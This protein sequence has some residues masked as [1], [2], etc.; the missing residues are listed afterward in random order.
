MKPPLLRHTLL[1]LLLLL[2]STLGAS[3][4]YREDLRWS[5]KGSQASPG[6]YF[7]PHSG[8]FRESPPDA[9][10]VRSIEDEIAR[11]D[12]AVED[13][14]DEE[15]PKLGQRGARLSALSNR[16]RR[17]KFS[18]RRQ[19]QVDNAEGDADE[20]GSAHQ[21]R[22]THYNDPGEIILLSASNKYLSDRAER[23]NKQYRRDKRRY[24][25]SGRLRHQLRYEYDESH[26]IANAIGEGERDVYGKG[27]TYN[28]TT[29]DY[30]IG[31][32]QRDG[33]V[34]E[35]PLSYH[36]SHD[37]KYY[38]YGERPIIPTTYRPAS[39]NLFEARRTA[40]QKTT[41]EASTPTTTTTSEPFYPTLSNWTPEKRAKSTQKTTPATTTAIPPTTSTKYPK[42]EHRTTTKAPRRRPKTWRPSTNREVIRERFLE[43]AS[44][45][46]G[47]RNEIADEYPSHENEKFPHFP[48]QKRKTRPKIEFPTVKKKKPKSGAA[49]SAPSSRAKAPRLD[50]TLEVD[51]SAA[52][53][54]YL[55][56]EQ[57][58]MLKAKKLNLLSKASASSLDDGREGLKKTVK[59]GKKVGGF[60]PSSS[61]RTTASVGTGDEWGG[62]LDSTSP[63]SAERS[64]TTENAQSLTY[65]DDSDRISSLFLPAP[66]PAADSSPNLP[67]LTPKEPPP[68]AYGAP[69]LYGQVVPR[70]SKK[71]NHV[72]YD[73]TEEREIKKRPTSPQREAGEGYRQYHPPKVNVLAKDG[74]LSS[75]DVDDDFF[76]HAR[77][78]KRRENKKNKRHK[79]QKAATLSPYYKPALSFL[80]SP[81]PASAPSSRQSSRQGFAAVTVRPYGHPPSLHR[82]KKEEKMRD[83]AKESE[84]TSFSPQQ[85]QRERELYASPTQRSVVRRPPPSEDFV[86]RQN[87]QLRHREREEKKTTTKEEEKS[88]SLLDRQALDIQKVV[89][90][91]ASQRKMT[92]AQLMAQLSLG[93]FAPQLARNLHS[94]SNQDALAH[95]RS[96]SHISKKTSSSL[97]TRQKK[98]PAQSLIHPF[99]DGSLGYGFPMQSA[100]PRFPD[101]GY[102]PSF[103]TFR[104]FPF[105]QDTSRSFSL[106]GGF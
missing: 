73:E 54:T 104:S 86:R 69:D 24:Q 98:T 85:H 56:F 36:S 19:L 49:T 53:G 5:S 88:S 3:E 90:S 51:G 31:E 44:G 89:K 68:T 34:T 79:I 105:A 45:Q 84:T 42:Y 91:P 26:E 20:V 40:A 102:V 52:K 97:S 17:T 77:H 30:T 71:N 46:H 78:S 22:Y 72:Y 50:K 29:Y 64:T 11:G 87:H 47:D 103:S 41:T 39:F 61:R 60:T 2:S 23:K 37:G 7:D 38:S 15:S 43:Y 35:N 63:R 27:S 75:H 18:R 25:S 1:P 100:F 66:T 57:L 62:R 9:L 21:P 12:E 6:L 83:A 28:P 32:A 55:P 74:F 101:F 59:T 93:N 81:K 33:D 94:S 95:R 4:A 92:K 58:K 16:R 96:S 10:L 106:K 48:A 82:I 99:G 76:G 67:F 14:V 70:H 8:T 65:V 13:G 80:P